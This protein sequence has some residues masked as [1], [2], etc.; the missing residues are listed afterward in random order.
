MDKVKR[1]ISIL[2][3]IIRHCEGI[4]RTH[5]LFN[6]EIDDFD[7]ENPYF[8]AISMDLLQIGELANHLSK[9]FQKKYK[10]I[11]YAVIIALR[12][13][14][15]HGYGSLNNQRV[16]NTSH[17]DIPILRNRCLEILGELEN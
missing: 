4:E 8:K 17:D 6:N 1:D 10:D 14:V 2:K 9:E 5:T 7:F 13:I 16:W 15:V 3:T 12:N 11:P